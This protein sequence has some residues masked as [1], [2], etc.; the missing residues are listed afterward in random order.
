MEL[1]IK[2]FKNMK[3]TAEE[4]DM[5][6]L[7]VWEILADKVQDGTGMMDRKVV[8]KTGKDGEHIMVKGE[9]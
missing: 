6:K 2:G 8:A 5:A 9:T 7:E 3:Y 4:K 1:V